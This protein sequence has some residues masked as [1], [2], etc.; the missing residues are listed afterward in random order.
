M[1]QVYLTLSAIAM[2]LAAPVGLMPALGT[3]KPLLSLGRRC[4]FDRGIGVLSRRLGRLLGA[5]AQAAA[6]VNPFGFAADAGAGGRNN[7]RG[8]RPSALDTAIQD[9][10]TA[11]RRAS[12][13][14]ERE[15]K[16]RLGDK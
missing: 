6:A 4:L 9:E 1:K 7:L 8:R 12:L 16:K 5:A 13:A 3:A 14:F 15:E 2:A 10:R 11:E